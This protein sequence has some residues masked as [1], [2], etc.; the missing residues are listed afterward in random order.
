[1]NKRIFLAIR[2]NP[3]VPVRDLFDLLR[4]EAVKYCCL[5]HSSFS[6]DICSPGYFTKRQQPSVIFLQSVKTKEL[7][8]LQGDLDRHF[9]E[10]GIPKEEREFKPYLTLGRVKL[11]RDTGVFYDLMKQF[12][13]RPV[14]TIPVG[15]L[16]LFE[17]SLK[18]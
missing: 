3:E 16:I 12:P 15:E 4:D 18:P 8:A 1:M 5:R 13:Q 11:E 7:D 2:I 14:Q 17:S 6:F 9:A 10:L